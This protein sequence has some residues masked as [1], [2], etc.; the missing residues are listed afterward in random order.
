MGNTI[1]LTAD[2]ANTTLPVEFQRPDTGAW[3]DG[4]LVAGTTNTYRAVLTGIPA[5][6]YANILKARLKG[7]NPEV[8]YVFGGSVIVVDSNAGTTPSTKLATPTGLSV[9]PMTGSNGA[10]WNSVVNGA[11]YRLQRAPVTN[12]TAGNFGTVFEDTYLSYADTTATAGQVYDYR[13]KAIGSGTYTDS[14]YSSTFRVTTATA[15]APP[16]TGQS[17]TFTAAQLGQDAYHVAKSGYIQ[18]GA[19]TTVTGSSN[20]PTM[21]VRVVSP[22]SQPAGGQFVLYVNGNFFSAPTPARTGSLETVSITGL[23]TTTYTWKLVSSSAEIV[24]N[25]DFN[26][27]FFVGVDFASGTSN[28]VDT[29]SPTAVRGVVGGDSISVGGN[30]SVLSQLGWVPV[31]R[32]LTGYNIAI[33]GWAAKSA[34]AAF[35]TATLRQAEASRVKAYLAGAGRKFYWYCL[36]TNDYGLQTGSAATYKAITGALFDEINQQDPSIIIYAQAPLWRENE[37]AN[38]FGNTLDDYRA[39]LSQVAA[40]RSGFVR[41]VPTTG[42][43]NTATD[44]QD[45]PKLHPNDA[46]H[47]KYAAFVQQE[48]AKP[49]GNPK[50]TSSSG[51]LSLIGS[52]WSRT[53]V[54]PAGAYE[55][56][57]AIAPAGAGQIISFAF[58]SPE[59]VSFRLNYGIGNAG[60]DTRII[61]NGGTP[62]ASTQYSATSV[63]QSGYQSATLPAGD[64]TVSFESTTTETGRSFYLE[65]VTLSTPAAAFVVPLPQ[66][67]S[68]SK[69]NEIPGYDITLFGKNLTNAQTA[70]LNGTSLPLGA[71]TATSQV[72]T[73]PAG[74]TSGDLV[75]TTFA[76]TATFPYTV[77]TPDTPLVVASALPASSNAFTYL[78]AGAWTGP[79]NTAPAASGS[80]YYSNANGA[81]YEFTATFA[82][83]QFSFYQ[84]GYSDMRI[85][86]DGVLVATLP[87]NGP[88][89]VKKYFVTARVALGSHLVRVETIEG[90]KFVSN[91][92]V[93]VLTGNNYAFGLF[94]RS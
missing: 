92:L 63:V 28:S 57:Q 48:L 9:V 40:S 41:Y 82:Q 33:T 94:D 80:I 42:L 50:L 70:T 60:A 66:L 34:S 44:Y 11:T 54:T 90:G 31:L 49:L 46:G 27:T 29:V 15:A 87:L 71:N 88:D 43:L 74:V 16:A 75:L 56:Q 81:A 47:A 1:T 39:A 21:G 78:P 36:G 22:T 26:A 7:S 30:A 62:I 84:G 69:N 58:T 73:L 6:T 4:Q 23:P 72:V 93:N 77:G 86:I 83:L 38:S 52:G 10:S 32:G 35:P 55:P 24:N 19:F 8:F 89:N 85:L 17:L 64:Y 61:I 76:G 79:V 2:R 68:V 5:G 59:S 37:T 65:N 13:V 18:S 25:T 14:D 53:G 91:D 67:T 20:S 12:G 51:A 3:V 45:N